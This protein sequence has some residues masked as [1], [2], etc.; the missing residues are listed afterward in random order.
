MPIQ[1]VTGAIAPEALGVTLMHEHIVCAISG[2]GVA[3]T[4]TTASW[5]TKSCKRRNWHGTARPAAR[6]SWT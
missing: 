6:R 2:S 5:M 4:S 1:T 3:G